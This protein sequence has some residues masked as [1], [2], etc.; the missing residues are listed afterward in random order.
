MPWAPPATDA[1]TTL[2]FVSSTRR[3]LDRRS[4]LHR[5]LQSS[6]PPFACTASPAREQLLQDHYRPLPTTDVCKP[7]GVCLPSTRTR[8]RPLLLE[9]LSLSPPKAS[10][11]ISSADVDLQED[12]L[13]AW[14]PQLVATVV[15]V[16]GCIAPAMATNARTILFV[17]L[18]AVL[19]MRC[20]GAPLPLPASSEGALARVVRSATEIVT[21]LFHLSV[22]NPDRDCYSCLVFGVKCPKKCGQHRKH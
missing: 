19:A 12:L 13:W 3:H 1:C 18:A 20:S 9:D 7:L 10:S 15:A 4:S 16:T 22:R 14:S 6:L 11:D 2:S 8:H 17:V 21:T 5:H